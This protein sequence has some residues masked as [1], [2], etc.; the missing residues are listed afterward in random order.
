VPPGGK[1]F[2]MIAVLVSSAGALVTK[3]SLMQAV[4]PAGESGERFIG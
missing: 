4:W 2:D 3:D 1:A